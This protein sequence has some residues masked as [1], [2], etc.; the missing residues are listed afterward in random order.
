MIDAVWIILRRKDRFLLVQRSTSDVAGG[1]WCF[2]EGKVDEADHTITDALTRELREETGV[3]VEYSVPLCNIN[4]DGYRIH[5]FNCD[6]WCGHPKPM[7]EDV[8]GIGWFKL[9]EIYLLDRSLA[10]FLNKNLMYV[11]YMIQHYDH[12]SDEWPKTH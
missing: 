1:T 4:S 8:I 6:K 9:S 3:L 10:P 5:I 7:C 11:A 12:H 2:P